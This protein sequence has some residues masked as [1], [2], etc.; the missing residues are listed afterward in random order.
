MSRSSTKG[1]KSSQLKDFRM[2]DFAQISPHRLN[3]YFMF[4]HTYTHT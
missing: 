2:M 4:T 3:H 1:E